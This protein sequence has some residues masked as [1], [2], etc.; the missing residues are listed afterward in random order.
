MPLMKTGNLIEKAME[1]CVSGHSGQFREG[2][3]PLPYASHPFDVVHRLRY[4]GGVEDEVVLC[5]AYLH[6]LLEETSVTAHQIEE[7]F[8]EDVKNLV[9]EVTRE[10]PSEEQTTG[11][12]SDEIYD[13]RNQMLMDEIRS[14][15][16]EAMAIKLADRISNVTAARVTRRGK[17]L[18]RYIK[19][20]RQMLEIIPRTANE[21]LWKRLNKLVSKLEEQLD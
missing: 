6:D 5:A 20:S 7:S 2:D 10:E 4:E 15:S 18:K 13:L 12:T 3:T 17:R 16:E 8:G 9:L 19:Q 11:L 1:V 14:M 21:K